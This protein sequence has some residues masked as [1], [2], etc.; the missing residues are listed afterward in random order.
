[1]RLKFIPLGFQITLAF[2]VVALF[3]FGWLS[4]VS[5]RQ[6]RDGTQKMVHGQLAT[7]ANE[8]GVEIERTVSSAFTHIKVLADNPTIRSD[9]ASIEEK[10]AET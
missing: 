10:L 7:L 9:Q 6:V 5:Y 3:P 8:V 1:M 4:V 2:L